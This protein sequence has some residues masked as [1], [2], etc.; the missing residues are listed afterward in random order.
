[1]HSLVGY[2][3]QGVTGWWNVKN[4]LLDDSLTERLKEA[5]PIIA[6]WA[7]GARHI[8]TSNLA[9]P[10]HSKKNTRFRECFICFGCE[11][12][13]GEVRTYFGIFSS[14]RPMF[15]HV[16]RKLLPRH[17]NYIA[18][19]WSILKNNR[20]TTKIRPPLRFSLFTP[21]TGLGHPR[22][23]SVFTAIA[24]FSPSEK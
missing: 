14:Y 1:M 12:N 23:G 16:N 18:E 21:K 9:K 19:D 8:A 5:S 10:I 17:S 3:K 2:V 11:T 22:T 4:E 7:S 20:N 6:L 15:S 24:L 13:T